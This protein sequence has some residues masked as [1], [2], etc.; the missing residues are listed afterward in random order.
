M[1]GSRTVDEL[2]SA[3]REQWS[4]D[5]RLAESEGSRGRLVKEDILVLFFP[6]RNKENALFLTALNMVERIPVLVGV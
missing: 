2:E 4:H 3:R 6:F 1:A 5:E